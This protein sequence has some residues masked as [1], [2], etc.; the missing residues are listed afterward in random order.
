MVKLSNATTA[1]AAILIG[2]MLSIWAHA[3]EPSEKVQ[4]DDVE[5]DEITAGAASDDEQMVF[6][7]VRRT[8]SGNTITADGSFKVLEAADLLSVGQLTLTDHA[9]QNLRSVVN[10][11]AVN[12]EVNVLLNLNVTIDSTVGTVNQFN[13]NGALPR[14]IP[15]PGN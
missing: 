9:Q 13:L 14:G 15:A 3:D 8:R 5:L 1:F 4:L 7:I 6:N 10:I 11:N 12:S 2:T